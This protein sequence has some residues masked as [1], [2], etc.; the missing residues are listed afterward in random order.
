MKS[1]D[2]QVVQN[3]QNENVLRCCCVYHQRGAELPCSS[4]C[5]NKPCCHCSLLVLHLFT[6]LCQYYPLQCHCLIF[7]ICSNHMNI[8]SHMFQKASDVPFKHVYLLG[9]TNGSTDCVNSSAL[10]LLRNLVRSNLRV[11]VV[12]L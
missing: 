10:C 9:V 6:L 7:L 4:S 2:V 11:V 1:F 8:S 12:C 5:L 3:V